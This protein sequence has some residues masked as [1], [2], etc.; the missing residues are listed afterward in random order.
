MAI[1]ST[2]CN[3]QKQKLK[4][5]KPDCANCC[6]HCCCYHPWN[7]PWISFCLFCQLISLQR[8]RRRFSPPL[9]SVII[10]L[11]FLKRQFFSSTE[12]ETRFCHT[13]LHTP[14]VIAHISYY[15]IMLSTFFILPKIATFTFFQRN[16]KKE[17]DCSL[18]ST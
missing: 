10:R 7:S 14:H 17:A 9:L 15:W 3:G 12:V 18:H 5:K 2:W 13:T 6:T 8:V 16:F 1:F 11:A 4:T